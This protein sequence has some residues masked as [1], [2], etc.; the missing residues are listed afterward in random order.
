MDKKASSGFAYLFLTFFLWGSVYVAGKLGSAQ[1]PPF[2][3][4]ALRCAIATPLLLLMARECP[5]RRIDPADRKLFLAVGLLGYYLT[6]DLVQLGVS[7]TGASVA[8]LV[9]SF[10]PVAIML[11]AAVLLKER[12]TPVKLLCLALAMTGTL[13]VAGGAHGQGEV[14]GILSTLLATVTWGGAAVCIRKLAAK[15]PARVVTAYGMAISLLLHIPTGLIDA[16]RR[17]PQLSAS[18][19]LTVLYLA[20]AGTALAQTTWARA[21]AQFP[22]GTCSLFYPLQ[23]VFSALLGAAI[24]HERFTPA[25]FIGLVFVTADIALSTWETS[26]ETKRAALTNE[27]NVSD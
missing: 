11:L 20:F 19:V 16:L 26:R 7:L 4:S 24:L 6:F 27:K 25:F 9:N 22:A 15:Y 10:N 14:L 2:L 5:R 21:L 17:P 1:L 18:G 3:L 8:A 13:I 23:A 12:V